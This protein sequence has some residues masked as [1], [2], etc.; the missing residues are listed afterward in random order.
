VVNN[1][2]YIN[3]TVE[4]AYEFIAVEDGSSVSVVSVGE[5]S[6][7]GSDTA[8]RKAATQA[9]KISHLH[10]FTIPN[11]EFD[12]E[13]SEPRVAQQA[14]PKTTPAK[15]AI[16]TAT[17]SS[18]ESVKLQAEVREFIKSGAYTSEQVNKIGETVATSLG[19]TEFVK[20]D[21]E[22]LVGLV[23]ELRKGTVE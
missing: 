16:A 10:A 14:S 20:S 6:D 17:K 1:R 4:A 15:R 11:S 2:V 13:G 9:L 5:G 12:D 23:A 19:K 21:E 18:N 7:I 22:T 8:T 3:V